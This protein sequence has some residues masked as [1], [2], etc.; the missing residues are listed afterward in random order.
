MVWWPA[1]LQLTFA[2]T[3]CLS[4]TQATLFSKAWF[5]NLFGIQPLPEKRAPGSSSHTY[6]RYQAP[7]SNTSTP[8]TS[9][10]LF[11]GI[12][13]T[14]SDLMKAAEKQQAQKASKGRLTDAEKRHAKAYEER[15]QRELAEEAVR[16]RKSAQAKFEREQE[17]MTRDRE[18]DERLRRRAEKAKRQQ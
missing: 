6:P 1:C 14:V 7:S 3:A 18:R 11:G 15:R 10:G 12:K 9:T 13:S 16:T 8:E 5:R 17:Q 2:T 4:A